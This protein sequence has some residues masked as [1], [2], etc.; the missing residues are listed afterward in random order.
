[1]GVGTV[2]GGRRVHVARASCRNATTCD[3]EVVSD[4]YDR[5]RDVPSRMTCDTIQTA[6]DSATRR[7]C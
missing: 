3:G 5:R 4:A 6:D 1:M 2:A 7:R